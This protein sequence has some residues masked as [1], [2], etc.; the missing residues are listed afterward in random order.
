MDDPF[1][2][3]VESLPIGV[4][5]PPRSA[6]ASAAEWHLPHALCA[7]GWARRAPYEVICAHHGEL[8]TRAYNE[9]GMGRL[10]GSFAGRERT[11]RNF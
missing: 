6:C 10:H 7:S 5:T 8:H 1:D 11:V 9:T 2:D 4:G 3:A